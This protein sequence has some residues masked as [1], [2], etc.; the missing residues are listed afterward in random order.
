[1]VFDAVIDPAAQRPLPFRRRN[2][3]RGPECVQERSDQQ[4]QGQGQPRRSQGVNG[5][6]FFRRPARSSLERR[7]DPQK[8]AFRS[9]PEFGPQG[10]EIGTLVA[11]APDQTPV[12][13]AGP[14]LEEIRIEI[15]VLQIVCL[16]GNRLLQD[17]MPPSA[18]ST[19]PV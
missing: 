1:M 3:Q 13:L 10:L 7:P 4:H 8:H 6:D 19:T 2:F 14:A 12:F 5:P 11:D 16:L 15:A 18:R 9:V 17:P